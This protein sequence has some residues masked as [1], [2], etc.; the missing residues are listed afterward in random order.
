[1]SSTYLWGKDLLVTPV[2]AKGASTAEVYFPARS[3]WFDFYTGAK[4]AG[5]ISDSVKLE[6]DHVPVYVRAGAFIPMAKV[7][8]STRDYN[9][10]H[11]ELHYYHDASGQRRQ[12]Q[13]V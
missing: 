11:I 1:M 9:T 2:L 4:H 13:A 3:A 7:V 12:R 10:K 8:Q 6:A 5:G